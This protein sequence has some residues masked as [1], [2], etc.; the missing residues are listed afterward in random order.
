MTWT[1]ATDTCGLWQP[2][3]VGI[4][5][6]TSGKRDGTVVQIEAWDAPDLQTKSG[7]HIGMSRSDLEALF[8]DAFHPDD[9]LYI[10]KDSLG[11]VVFDVE[12]D[13]VAYMR[14]VAA[15]HKVTATG[16]HGFCD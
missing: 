16:G 15:D 2:K 13:A 4:A 7:A 11:Q 1:Q 10:V 8:P 6:A 12:D 5:V 9:R 3:G 14:V